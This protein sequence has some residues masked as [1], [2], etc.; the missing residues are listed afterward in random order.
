MILFMHNAPGQEQIA[1]DNTISMI[2]L[3]FRSFSHFCDVSSWYYNRR[4]DG[5]MDGQRE[6]IIPRYYSMG[7]KC[8]KQIVLAT[9]N[10]TESVIFIIV[11]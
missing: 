5:Q 8:L 3:S 6:S 1:T 2:L 11:H 4:T 9:L 10:T 7:K